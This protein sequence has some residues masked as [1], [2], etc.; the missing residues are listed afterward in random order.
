MHFLEEKTKLQCCKSTFR[1]TQL[2]ISAAIAITATYYNGE[3]PVGPSGNLIGSSSLSG[4]T[5]VKVIAWILSVLPAMVYLN[6][7]KTLRRHDQAHPLQ[8][9]HL[10]LW[11]PSAVQFRHARCHHLA[12]NCE[13]AVINLCLMVWKSPLIM[14]NWFPFCVVNPNLTLALQPPSSLQAQHAAAAFLNSL[15]AWNTGMFSS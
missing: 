9:P 5:Q 13:T 1:S 15:P 7:I 11:H 6:Y 10:L 4:T 2:V 12:E 3:H 8:T 14:A